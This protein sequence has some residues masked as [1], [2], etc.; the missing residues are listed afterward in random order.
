M[1]ARTDQQPNLNL[2][3]I[4]KGKGPEFLAALRCRKGGLPRRQIIQPRCRTLERF[5]KAFIA[6]IPAE[7]LMAEFRR[8]K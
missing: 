6:E 3:A 5:A 2:R 1:P 8:L 7:R 4:G